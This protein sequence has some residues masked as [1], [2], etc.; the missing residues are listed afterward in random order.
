MR[1]RDRIAYLGALSLFLSAIE[2][3]IPRIIPF[4]RIG[5]ANI[6]VMAALGLPVWDFSIL[7][8]IK[9]AGT[10]Y[11]SGTLFS[12]FFLMSL[13]QTVLAGFTMFFLKKVSKRISVY[14]ISAAG[15]LVSDAVQIG[16]ASLYAGKG[17]LSILPI[18]L[19]LSLP[20]S[21]L[22]AAVSKRIEI[23]EISYQMEIN[24]EEKRSS[25]TA[26]LAFILSALALIPIGNPTMA[27]AAA[28]SCMR[29]HA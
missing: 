20:A 1:Y 19:I 29:F 24:G 21:I 16:I 3:L 9:A 8:F 22:T 28:V 26:I 10:S 13:S 25:R 27:A 17:A 11:I 14:S 7:L 4:F 5:L 2:I 18:M 23:P 6:P 12:P 15:A